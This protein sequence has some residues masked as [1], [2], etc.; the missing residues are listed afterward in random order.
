MLSLAAPLALLLLP[1][2]WLLMRILP[3]ARA[4][5]P[6]L[7]APEATV[8]WFARRAETRTGAATR[9]TAALPWA[10]WLF[11]VAALAGPRLIVPTPALPVTGRDLMIALDLSGSMV[12]ED[13]FLDGAEITRHDAVK[14]VGGA[15]VRGRGGDRV[16]LVIFG[17]EAYVAAPLSYD[18]ET[19]AQVI[20]ESVIGISGRA[21]NI[22]DG[23][24]LSMKRLAASEAASKVVILLSDG[25]SNAG[26][27]RPRDVAKLAAG[28]G[29]RVHT[30]ALGPKDKATAEAGERGVVDAATLTAMAEMSG[31]T[32]FRVRTLD[33]LEEVAQALDRLEATD[34]AG[35]PA[36]IYRPLWIWPAMVGMFC[37]IAGPV[38]GRGR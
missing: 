31:G 11:L 9:I 19:I 8:A 2:P 13:F 10:G 35:V 32:A 3:P 23:L 14:R 36:E 22:G 34:R 37:L 29:I 20:E 28:M 1:L 25:A 30:I 17:A 5:D 18:V 33:D 7:I 21:T 16:G 27:A 12:R 4:T 38:A 24:G 15:F 26:A 6:A